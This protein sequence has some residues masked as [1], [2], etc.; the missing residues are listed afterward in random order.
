VDSIILI[1]TGITDD[2]LAVAK[3]VA[4]DKLIIKQMQ[5]PGS[6]SDARNRALQ[7]AAEAGGSWGVFLDTDERFEGNTGTIRGFLQSTTAD[8]INMKHDSL[9]YHKVS[10]GLQPQSSRLATEADN[11]LHECLVCSCTAP[12]LPLAC[13]GNVHRPHP[14]GLCPC[15][16][17]NVC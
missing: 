8:M 12:V 16:R 2:T 13:E 15:G 6:F 1:D 7:M 9:T 14:R 11:T 10:D 4:G 17:L 5:W 3:R